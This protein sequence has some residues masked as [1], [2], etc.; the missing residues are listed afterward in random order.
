MT[1]TTTFT[2]P[3]TRQEPAR[4]T[5]VGTSRRLW[6]TGAAAGLSA[7]VATS[8]VA[9]AAHAFG[10]SLEIGGKAIPLLGFAQLTLVATIIGTV[11]AV[12]MSHRAHRP[13][14]TFAITTVA[15]TVLSIVPDALADA[16]TATR[17]TLA[18]THVV[19]AAIVIPALTSRLSD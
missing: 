10:V 3:S 8:A 15:L 9:A 16:Q 19:A 5:T 1:A 4:S 12:V 18:L 2:A 13:A 17:V 6:K 14:R 7:A 11:I